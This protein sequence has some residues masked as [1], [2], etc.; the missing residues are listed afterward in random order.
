MEPLELQKR[1]HSLGWSYAEAARQLG[2]SRGTI[3]RWVRGE[4]RI[5]E[6]AMR[7]LEILGE[8][9]TV[10][11]NMESAIPKTGKLSPFE[12]ELLERLVSHLSTI[13]EVHRILVFG[14]RARGFSN[15][16]S[17]LD[18]AVVT[19]TMDPASRAAV[20][21]AKWRA[22]SEDA[23]LYANVVTITGEELAAN[24]AFSRNVNKEGI[25]IW[26]RREEPR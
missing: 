21:Q 9:R 11:R 5:P 18:V 23:F 4:R 17:D 2:V 13:R 22:L 7:L 20:E 3:S 26:S 24:T 6:T 15:E 16:H 12:K 14:S 25:E 1:L 19:D 10:K 8:D